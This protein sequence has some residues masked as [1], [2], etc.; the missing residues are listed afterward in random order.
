MVEELKAELPVLNLLRQVFL[1]EPSR[2]LLEAIGEVVLPADEGGET[3]GLAKMVDSVQRNS[4]R[5]NEWA[6]EI[7]L[8]FVRL[9]IGPVHPPA[10]PFASF[11]LSESRSLMTEETLE[12][13]KRYLEAGLALKDLHQI[14][15]D[16]I[17]MEI[18]FFYYLTREAL[19]S[20]EGGK[21]E[22]ASKFLT[23]RIDFLKEHMALWVP[24]F[25][26]RIIL[27]SSE[28]FFNGAATLLREAIDAY[29]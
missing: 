9:F 26:E 6:E 16:H 24:V 14:P 21:N 4:S 25:V 12:V 22:E 15:D 19:H 10:V 29:R 2:N 17:A 23:L 28:D 7:S 5:L 11:Y 18:E 27:S 20:M 8:E 3:E 13:R 1:R